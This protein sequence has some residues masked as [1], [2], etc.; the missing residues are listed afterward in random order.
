M[1]IDVRPTPAQLLDAI[2]QCLASGGGPPG[3]DDDFLNDCDDDD[4]AAAASDA[5]NCASAPPCATPAALPYASASA[6]ASSASSSASS[7]P[8]CGA[9][10]KSA[11]G[12]QGLSSPSHAS[13]SASSA[14]WGNYGT[15]G[16]GGVSGGSGAADTETNQMTIL[17]ELILACPPE[18][19]WRAFFYDDEA[20]QAVLTANEAQTTALALS[21]VESIPLPSLV[22]LLRVCTPI[23]FERLIKSYV[24][25][26]IKDSNQSLGNI[27]TADATGTLIPRFS[28]F[29]QPLSKNSKFFLTLLCIISSYWNAKSS[30][31]SITT[32]DVITCDIIP[33]V[34]AVPE[35]YSDM[36]WLVTKITA[37]ASTVLV[38]DSLTNTATSTSSSS[39]ATSPPSTQ[40]ELV[41]IATMCIHQVAY[42]L[43]Q[44]HLV[45]HGDIGLG[46]CQ[47]VPIA[48][49]LHFA[50]NLFRCLPQLP[51]TFQQLVTAALTKH[52]D[53]LRLCANQRGDE[54][55]EQVAESISQSL[56]LHCGEPL[57][58]LYASFSV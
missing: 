58:S 43:R 20:L 16:G 11:A 39:T 5:V 1:D 56:H 31:D 15:P 28:C 34:I 47:H 51:Q 36:H 21:I 52:P 23:L 30:P 7:A 19:C 6:S 53:L 37:D 4:A 42:L 17:A 49:S 40:R 22:E 13:P 50:D 27:V 48:A 8:T 33:F 29:M 12:P 9:R 35:R 2:E 44:F 26:Q 18:S 41:C 10:S 57:V 24:D 38:N 32:L 3:V 46:T 54:Q 55:H 45:G 14:S 25:M